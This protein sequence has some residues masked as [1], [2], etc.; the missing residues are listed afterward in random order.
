M[1]N[2]SPQSRKEVANVGEDG[3]MK[4]SRENPYTQWRKM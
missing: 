3:G 1:F 2:L 4:Q